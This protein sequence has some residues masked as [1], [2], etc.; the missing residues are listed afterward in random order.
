MPP[1]INPHIIADLLPPKPTRDA[2]L[3]LRGFD[4]DF[5]VYLVDLLH[6]LLAVLIEFA[7]GFGELGAGAVGL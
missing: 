7:F 5:S 2:A 4:F 6:C 1:N 3:R